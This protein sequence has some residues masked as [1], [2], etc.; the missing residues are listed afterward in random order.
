M[1]Y[2]V[3][4]NGECVSRRLDYT[5]AWDDYSV[6]IAAIRAVSHSEVLAAP[7]TIELCENNGSPVLDTTNI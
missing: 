2:T 5:R 4:V 7:V 3:M 6:T 1:S